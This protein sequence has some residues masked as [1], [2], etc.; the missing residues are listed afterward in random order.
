M[1]SDEVDENDPSSISDDTTPPTASERK[2]C[3]ISTITQ[4]V[5]HYSETLIVESSL[6]RSLRG[7]LGVRIEK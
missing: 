6:V 4:T 1:A 3:K 5:A 7:L 2:I